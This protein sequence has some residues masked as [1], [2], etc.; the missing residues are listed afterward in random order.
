MSYQVRYKK[1]WWPF[2]RRVKQVK[3][4]EFFGQ[5]RAL[6]LDAGGMML[7]PAQ[8]LILEFGPERVQILR[9]QAGQVK[10]LQDAYPAQA[11]GMRLQVVEEAPNP[12]P[13]GHVALLLAD[14]RRLELPPSIK[15][16]FEAKRLQVIAKRMEQTSGLPICLT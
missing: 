1:P 15:I 3:G 14:D 9:A 16:S 12:T 2:W 11:G 7:L 10:Q 8:G 5:A 4:D 13:T 6:Y